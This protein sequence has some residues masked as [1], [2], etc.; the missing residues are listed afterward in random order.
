MSVVFSRYTYDLPLMLFEK[1][2]IDRGYVTWRHASWRTDVQQLDA[3]S[4]VAFRYLGPDEE[5]SA[6][7]DRRTGTTLVTLD[8]H[9]KVD[10]WLAATD[11]AALIAQLEEVRVALPAVAD[12]GDHELPVRFWT[13]GPSDATSVVRTVTV[14]LWQEIRDNYSPEVATVLGRLTARN[15]PA[16]GGQLM[17]WHGPPGTG[18]THAIRALVREWR[19]WVHAEYVVDPEAFF[20]GAAGYLM[21]LLLGET[22]EDDAE[23]WRLLIFEDTGELLAADAKERVGQGLS[24]LL[25]TVDGLLGQGLRVLLLMTTNED[26][27]RLHPA[28][29]RPGRCAVNLRFGALN[30]EAAA[31]WLARFG[32]EL[33]AGVERATLA[34][35]F[36][37]V[38]GLDTTPSGPQP[39]GFAAPRR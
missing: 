1:Q 38:E 6:R 13:M 15:E 32:V 35:L 28:I 36:A 2:A 10:A 23:K 29:T 19:D 16:A 3:L 11:D 4:D 14:P 7:L 37:L 39:I 24:R 20:G 30:R 21:T 26:F 12:S 33:P 8:R 18:K 25:N 17:L 9:G 31:A 27:G 34:E 5:R 22:D